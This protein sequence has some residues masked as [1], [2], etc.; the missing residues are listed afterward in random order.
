MSSP[1]SPPINRLINDHHVCQSDVASAYQHLAQHVNI[2][3]PVAPPSGVTRNSGALGQISK[4]S[5][6][7]PFSTL[8]PLLLPPSYLPSLS[9]PFPFPPYPFTSFP[10]LPFLPSLLFSTPSF[11]FP[12]SPP[13]YNG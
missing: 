5:P 9:L 7:S 1:K 6:P 11:P 13:P 8:S 3:T 12:P 2:P 4:W 10:S